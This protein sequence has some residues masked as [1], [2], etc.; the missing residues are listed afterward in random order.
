M[1]VQAT[2][3]FFDDDFSCEGMASLRAIREAGV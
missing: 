2:D 1:W 3:E